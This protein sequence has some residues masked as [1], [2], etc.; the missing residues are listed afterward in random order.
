[1]E[2]KF[3]FKALLC[4][5][6]VLFATSATA[7]NENVNANDST[8]V[9]QEQV[10]NKKGQT[11]RPARVKKVVK[12]KNGAVREDSVIYKGGQTE[13]YSDQAVTSMTDAILDGILDGSINAVKR[14]NKNYDGQLRRCGYVGAVGGAIFGDDVDP[15][16]GLMVGYRTWNFDF[17]LSGYWSQGHLPQ[18]SDEPGAR[19]N[20][21]YFYLDAT[22]K[23]LH[24]SNG[25]WSFGPGAGLGYGAQKTNDLDL[26]GSTNSGVTGR[27][28]LAMSYQAT[29]H[30]TL[31]LKAGAML[32]VLVDKAEN[33]T[34]WQEISKNTI[35][36]FIAAEI[37]VNF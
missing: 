16:A 11:T 34:E 22:W 4:G 33:G 19:Y 17:S 8:V 18:H 3:F 13:V 12:V 24:T 15:M 31:G 6:A 5:V 2:A 7:Q 35:K 9:G 25:Y 21:V 14:S 23:A 36:P 28:F 1:M 32:K 26:G 30:L 27:A 10:S 29:R 37:K 20:S